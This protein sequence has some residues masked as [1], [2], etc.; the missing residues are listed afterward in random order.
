MAF[1]NRGVFAE[2]KVKDYLDGWQARDPYR[3]ASR[4]TDSKA[5]GR[6]I[7]AAAADFEYF[8]AELETKRMHGLIEVKETEHGYRLAR[9]K[10]PQL[11][12]LR[13]RQKCGGQCFVLSYHSKLKVWRVMTTPY[14]ANTGDTGSW[15]L[16]NLPTFKTCGEA[17]N[18]IVPDCFDLE[19]P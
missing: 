4:L 14:L 13:K 16:T 11:P 8:S 5:A 18:Y 9:D 12:R 7:K 15:N 17:L 6:I 3:E 19:G 1:A 2:E 10:V